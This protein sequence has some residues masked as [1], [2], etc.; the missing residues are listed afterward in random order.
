MLRRRLFR[1]DSL[2]DLNPLSRILQ[3]NFFRRNIK[4][5]LAILNFI[6]STLDTVLFEVRLEFFF[7]R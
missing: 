1:I 2:D 5:K 6:V 3:A 4:A 7:K